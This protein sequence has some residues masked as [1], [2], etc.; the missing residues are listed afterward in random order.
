MLATTNPLTSLG[1]KA[2]SIEIG[3]FIIL[4]P[5]SVFSAYTS[6]PKFLLVAI[7]RVSTNVK[8]VVQFK[9]H[10]TLRWIQTPALHLTL[11]VLIR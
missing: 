6:A 11:A 10:D 9:H 2:S 7:I 5:L 3:A 1:M 4:L 8:I